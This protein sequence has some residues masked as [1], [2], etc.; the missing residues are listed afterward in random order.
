MLASSIDKFNLFRVSFDN[1][2]Y[3]FFFIYNYFGL[4]VRTF[5]K[6]AQCLINYNCN[7][8]AEFLIR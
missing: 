5:I 2:S 7:Y 8:E 1:N 4:N 6:F 3:V